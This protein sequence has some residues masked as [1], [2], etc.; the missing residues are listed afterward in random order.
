M[1]LLE[2]EEEGKEDYG[3]GGDKVRSGRRFRGGQETLK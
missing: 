2:V 1:R 3:E